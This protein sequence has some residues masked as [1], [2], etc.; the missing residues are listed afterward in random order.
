MPVN[1]V[2]AGVAVTDGGVLQLL[3]GPDRAG[4][5]LLT[6]NVDALGEELR[7]LRERGLDPDAVEDQMSDEVLFAPVTDPEGNTI[8]LVEER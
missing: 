3:G 7:R 4:R 5:S 1:G 6:L 2:L 8:T